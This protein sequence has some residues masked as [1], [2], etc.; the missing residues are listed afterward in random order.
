[1]LVNG[2]VSLDSFRMGADLQKNHIMII[3]LKFSSPHSPSTFWR[4]VE[5]EDNH[6]WPM[7]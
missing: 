1:M 5:L 4:E 7:I 6:H 2:W 3:R